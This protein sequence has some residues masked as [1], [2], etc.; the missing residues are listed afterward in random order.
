MNKKLHF[1]KELI[2]LILS[3]EKDSTWRLW[4]D[5]NLQIGDIVDFLES[6]TEKHFTTARIIKVI[7]KKMGELKEEDK[8]GHE[9]Y[10]NDRQM[11]KIY[12]GYYKK[13]VTPDTLVKIVRFELV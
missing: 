7:N 11:Y 12:S 2:S 13:D 8:K 10:G 4:D 3:G 9:K 6:K 5:K 1:S